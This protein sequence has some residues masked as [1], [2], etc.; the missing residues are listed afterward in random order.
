MVYMTKKIIALLVTVFIFLTN[1]TLVSATPK[2]LTE[3]PGQTEA[4]D[5]IVEAIK[6]DDVDKIEA[7]FKAFGKALDE[8]TSKDERITEVL[9]TKGSL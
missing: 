5:I 8:A 2:E 9:S 7:M 4:A 1:V 6:S 3:Y